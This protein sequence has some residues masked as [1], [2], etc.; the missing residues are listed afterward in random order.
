MQL[1]GGL[2]QR[3]WNRI[4][5]FSISS[6]SLKKSN[7]NFESKFPTRQRRKKKMPSSNNN[8]SLITQDGIH[9]SKNEKHLTSNH[10]NNP[11]ASIMLLCL[12][13]SQ[14]VCRIADLGKIIIF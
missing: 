13:Q 14:K 8:P 10:F 1:V 4:S 11:A 2:I 6:K 5:I 7:K 9:L 3:L 12:R